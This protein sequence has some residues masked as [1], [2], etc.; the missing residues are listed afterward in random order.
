MRAGDWNASAD[1]WEDLNDAWEW[2]TADRGE[3]DGFISKAS[4]INEAPKIRQVL[5]QHNHGD[6]TGSSDGKNAVWDAEH[7]DLKVPYD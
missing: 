4:C 3:S 5:G 6:L 7:F 1:G 2:G